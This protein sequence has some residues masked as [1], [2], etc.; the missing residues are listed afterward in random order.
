MTLRE[1]HEI[2][3][4]SKGISTDSRTFEKG[5]IYLAIKGRFC[6]LFCVQYLRIIINPLQFAPQNDHV[7]EL[8]L[9]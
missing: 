8:C 3:L 9:L 7:E 6:G 4:S 1:L 5:M 2:F